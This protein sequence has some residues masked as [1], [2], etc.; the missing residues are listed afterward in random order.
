MKRALLLTT[1]VAIVAAM[2]FAGVSSA[3]GSWTPIS[4]TVY[5]DGSWYTSTNVR[6]V[7]SGNTA[8]KV[9]F[10][11]IPT[12]NLAFYARNYQTGIRIGSI[13]Y[14]PPTTSQL[15]GN[16]AAG[17]QFVNVFKEQNVCHLCGWNYDFAGSEYY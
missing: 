11:Q 3:S 1:A 13:A 2:V 12:G 6:T 4:G 16:A 8:I 7:H 14:A 5:S 17:T 15:L 9:Q 10:S